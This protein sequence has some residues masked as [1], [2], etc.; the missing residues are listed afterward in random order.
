MMNV[1]V[2]GGGGR[3][4]AMAWKA[5]QSS[6]VD[7]VYCAPGNPGIAAL[8][9]GV[10]VDVNPE[11]FP[12][13][14]AL[15]AE[16]AI[17]LVLVGPEA[18]LAAG[19]TDALAASGA[20]VFGPVKAAAQLEA[21]KTFAKE[22]MARHQIPT[23]AYC[24]F[25]DADAAKAYVD[26]IGVPLVVK[27][28]GL[29][30]GKG[31]TVA[32]ERDEALRAIDDAMLNGV[33][34]DA[35][36]RIIIE[37]FL[38][39]EEASILA[40]ADGKTVVPMASSQDHKAAYDGDTGPNTGGMGAYSPAPLVTPELLD[41]IQRTI[42]QPCVDG[43][44]AEGS[45]YVGVLYAGLM[46][47]K[48]GP[49][50]VEFNCRFGDPET[51][52]VLPRLTTDLVDVAEA[53]CRGTLDKIDLAYTDRPAATVVMAS[54]GYPGSYPKGR[55][56]S[57]IADAD[58]MND[59]IVFHAGTKLDGNS[60]VTSG[61]RVL[62]VTALGENLQLAL[63]KAYEGVAAIH[64]EGAEYRKDIGQKAFKHLG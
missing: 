31:V 12:A 10:C 9:K 48:D 15:V 21:S 36:A 11:D 7:T 1:L 22:F 59:V 56:I 19:V 17:D 38:D 55:T 44:A 47:T 4:H 51:Q 16:K 3:E 42:L 5:A 58:A 39:G 29:A 20:L 33:F 54:E 23:A 35:G 60:L 50:V 28:D 52:V 24:A 46:I 64:F 8:T 13:V 6:R 57:G 40:F 14:L 26:Q 32:F 30:A 41:E 2:L 27:A 25:T 43:M 49:K 45:P 53:C 63:E 34:G 62:A 61:G 37:A 18:P